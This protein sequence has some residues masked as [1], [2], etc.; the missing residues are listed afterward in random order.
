MASED[1][2][3]WTEEVKSTQEDT[4]LVNLVKIYGTKK[5]A[6]ISRQLKEKHGINDK[7]GKQCR[8]RWN[9][10]LNPRLIDEPW[11]AQEEKILFEK[12]E[13]FGNK[14][15]IIAGFLKGRSDNATKNHFYSII[16]KN[17]RR[18]N[19]CR[20]EDQKIKG[21]VQELL[22]KEEYRKVLLKKPRHYYKRPEKKPKIDVKPPESPVLKCER[23][24]SKIIEKSSSEINVK[25]ASFSARRASNTLQLP[26][27]QEIEKPH[28]IVHPTPV[29][30]SIEEIPG[31]PLYLLSSYSTRNSSRGTDYFSFQPFNGFDFSPNDQRKHFNF[32]RDM[33]RSL[34]LKSSEDEF[35]GRAESRK[36][37]DKSEYM[38][39]G[40]RK[41]TD[42]ANF[43]RNESRKLSDK[44]VFERDNNR[45]ETFYEM[46]FP[47]FSPKLNFDFHKTPR[48]GKSR[49]DE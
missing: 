16:R 45:K 8:E 25:R 6:H 15:S 41:S 20:P 19:K 38:R 27:C 43:E 23:R 1:K 24:R 7:T 26:D 9:N 39:T 28:D 10:S 47:P 32:A 17:Q 34:S 21:N 46:T 2:K 48:N 42:Q 12:Q 44:I 36:S 14:W 31:T 33:H 13:K 4:F 37:T 40:S 18:Y 35:A 11:S 49:F 29:H 5:W 30:P 22:E 3:L